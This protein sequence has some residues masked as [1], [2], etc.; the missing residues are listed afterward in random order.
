M[1]FCTLS[2]TE[3]GGAESVM[4][5]KYKLLLT[6][7]GILFLGMLSL[8][9]CYRR[10]NKLNIQ[11]TDEL[12][13]DMSKNAYD[14]LVNNETDWAVTFAADV[15]KNTEDE[16]NRM[17]ESTV[18]SLDS[19]AR[20]IEEEIDFEEDRS[21]LLEELRDAC[22]REIVAAD[23]ASDYYLILPD[24]VTFALAGRSRSNKVNVRTSEEYLQATKENGRAVLGSVKEDKGNRYF[25]ISKAFYVDG[26]V[27]GVIVSEIYLEVFNEM[28]T[29]VTVGDYDKSAIIINDQII[30]PVDAFSKKTY[31]SLEW[32]KIGVWTQMKKTGNMILKLDGTP[33]YCVCRKTDNPEWIMCIFIDLNDLQ[34]WENQIK[35]NVEIASIEAKVELEKVEKETV[36]LIYI[37]LIMICLVSVFVILGIAN[38]FV[39]PI[40]T[41]VDGVSK[42][43]AGDLETVIEVSGKDEIGTLTETFNDMTAALKQ[44]IV[45]IKD[46]TAKEQRSK[47]EMELAVSVQQGML[48][49]EAMNDEWILAKGFNKPA[50]ALGGDF[51]DYF[52]TDNDHLLFVIADVS[53][54]G[55]PAA[56]F[57]TNGRLL[58]RELAKQETDPAVILKR[59]NDIL[60][61]NNENL[62]FIT[63][64]LCILDVRSG[65]L[66]YA[67]AGHEM[68][69]LKKE[70]GS[71]EPMQADSGIALGI[72]EGFIYECYE[73]HLD[74]GDTIFLFTDGVSDCTNKEGEHYSEE[75][76]VA[77]LNELEEEP[78]AGLIRVL[79]QYADGVEQ[80]DD[81]TMLNFLFKKKK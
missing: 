17:I 31:E 72:M 58:F 18:S 55:I 7:V 66:K 61:R 70:N 47:T 81:I 64:F 40:D 32:S 21:V 53:D 68:P 25:S 48:P 59:V 51:Y 8:T 43:K 20:R 62:Q 1:P 27:A 5:I 29:K 63:A 36:F 37:I 10:L 45:E 16:L 34:D 28:L 67:N 24:G 6:M 2:Q 44:Q 14:R 57:M 39:K 46:M 75:R 42:I 23:V 49:N 71:Y 12:I 77:T 30:E 65:E 9:I 35:N 4:K 38:R 13:S 56:L 22:A 73:A 15:L 54:K 60:S 78:I 33:Y 19:L 52:Y 3:K 79:G 74:P 41:L 69:F 76:L 80:F 50:R 11:M 26:E